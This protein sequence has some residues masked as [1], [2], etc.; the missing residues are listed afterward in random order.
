ML[1]GARNQDKGRRG[2]MSKNP[3]VIIDTKGLNEDDVANAVLS[4]VKNLKEDSD[5]E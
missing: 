5:K 3:V 2:K 1:T 4:E